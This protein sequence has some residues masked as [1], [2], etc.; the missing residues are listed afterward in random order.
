MMEPLYCKDLLNVLSSEGYCCEIPVGNRGWDF[1]T[2]AVVVAELSLRGFC[3]KD[4]R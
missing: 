2:F 4:V 3:H 1:E